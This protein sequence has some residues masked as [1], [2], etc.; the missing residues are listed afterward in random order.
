MHS[1]TIFLLAIGLLATIAMARPN[2]RPRPGHHNEDTSNEITE[3][4]KSTKYR[5]PKYIRIP[6]FMAEKLGHPRPTFTAKKIFNGKYLIISPALIFKYKNAENDTE[7]TTTQNPLSTTT[8]QI[9]IDE[10][11]IDS[12]EETTTTSAP[13]FFKKRSFS[14]DDDEGLLFS[15]D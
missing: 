8:E 11:T 3:G 5:L 1:T 9:I 4:H 15:D 14:M 7:T 6:G 13:S 10:T 12:G 2:K